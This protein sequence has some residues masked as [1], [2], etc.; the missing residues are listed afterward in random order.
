[1]QFFLSFVLVISFGTFQ[2]AF[3]D[4]NKV[5]SLADGSKQ[6]QEVAEFRTVV[7][8]DEQ[9]DDTDDRWVAP[10]MVDDMQKRSQVSQSSA[11]EEEAEELKKNK[12][13]GAGKKNKNEN[14]NKN[15]P[16]KK[17][18]KNKGMSPK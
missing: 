10:E 16:P 8:D 5:G 13:K 7:N 6:D 12:N 4:D 14:K 9:D 1:M 11:G 3:G 17:K 18:F 2:L 15:K